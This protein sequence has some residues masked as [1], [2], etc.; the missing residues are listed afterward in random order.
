MDGQSN[1]YVPKLWRICGQDI[2]IE[3][4]HEHEEDLPLFGVVFQKP[5]IACWIRRS[6]WRTTLSFF[7]Q[8][9]LEKGL[10][11]REGAA[12]EVEGYAV[13]EHLEET[14]LGT[15]FINHLHGCL[16][17]PCIFIS[18]CEER[19]EINNGYS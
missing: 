19:R 6:R 4:G 11:K 18:F 12:H 7:L 14:V 8:G 15:R 5:I 9:K 16:L 1:S 3:S 10:G 2:E 13:V 17:L